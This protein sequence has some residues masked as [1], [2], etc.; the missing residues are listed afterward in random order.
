M[1]SEELGSIQSEVSEIDAIQSTIR[2][3]TICAKNCDTITGKDDR[4]S[5]LETKCLSN[6]YIIAK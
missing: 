1:S 4:L 3:A 2:M 6:Y 5:G